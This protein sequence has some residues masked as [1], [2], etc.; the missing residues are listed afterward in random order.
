[1]RNFNPKLLNKI[2]I[3]QEINICS[4]QIKVKKQGTPLTNA[5]I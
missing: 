4:Q 5:E 1:M 2:D 3:T